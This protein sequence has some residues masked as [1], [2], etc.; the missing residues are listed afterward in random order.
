MASQVN[1]RI[2]QLSSA[3]AARTAE[4]DAWIAKTIPGLPIPFYASA[5]LRDSGHK[6]CCVDLNVFPAGFNNLCETFLARSVDIMRRFI[7]A[8]FGEAPHERVLVV[9]EAHTRNPFYATHLHGL[10]T[11]LRN[12]GLSVWIAAMEGEDGDTPA[13]LTT[14]DGTPVP[15]TPV[16]R[17]GARIAGVN[18]EQFDWILLN[19]DLSAGALEW[20]EGILQPI[21]PPMCLG[22][23]RRR[24]SEFFDN[25]N[26]T[27]DEFASAFSF[28]PWL[29]R[30]FTDVVTGV[31]FLKQDGIERV[32]AGVAGMLGA[33]QRKYDEYGIADAPQV[34]VKN[35]AG[36]YGIGIMV[37]Q[38]P[39]DILNMNRRTKNKMS[40]GKG[41]TPIREVLL[42]EAVPT[43]VQMSGVVMEPV[44]YTI[45]TE[46]IGSFLRANPERGAVDN[47]NAKGMTFYRYCTIDPP[48]TPEEC[49]CTHDGMTLY[50]LVSR[51]SVIAAAREAIKTCA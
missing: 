32:A 30:T 21:H 39:D 40:M 9:P 13:A 29:L 49:I 16:R 18:G 20:L 11:L 48:A 25:Y 3:L 37:V 17:D 34:F 23:H 42:Q 51:L 2:D 8:R 45:G 27:V 10:G 1:S 22:W 14:H 47:L 38:S 36:T 28:D 7:A 33:I 35:N 4:V 5:D 50:Q 24:K 26:Q 41:H 12:A 19:N 15:L 44:V 31:D 46:V 6:L 43:R